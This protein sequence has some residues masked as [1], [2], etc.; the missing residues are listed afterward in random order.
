M[1]SL[2]VSKLALAN[3]GRTSS[4]FSDGRAAGHC[5]DQLWPLRQPRLRKKTSPKFRPS[6]ARIR[7]AASS[8]RQRYMSPLERRTNRLRNDITFV[9]LYV[10][11][12]TG[13]STDS[14]SRLFANSSGILSKENS[15]VS[16][17][18]SHSA[19]GRASGRS[20]VFEPA[21]RVPWPAANEDGLP[22]RHLCPTAKVTRTGS[23]LLRAS[24]SR[25][26]PGLLAIRTQRLCHLG[27][28]RR[29]CARVDQVG[30][31]RLNFKEV[32][33]PDT[34]TELH[35]ERENCKD[36]GVK[37][38][39]PRDR[40]PVGC[41]EEPPIVLVVGMPYPQETDT[42]PRWTC[43]TPDDF[44]TFDDV[45]VGRAKNGLRSNP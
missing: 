40:Q 25:L 35:P 19:R 29:I 12:R 33:D 10:L 22:L 15:T 38:L 9:K 3:Q 6:D 4:I 36:I 45:P 5:G 8:L 31:P 7:K 2:R 20:L 32:R 44:D 21:L 16:F 43:R 23:L 30:A 42:M 1:S 11:P 39:G 14:W 18:A 27:N 26:R 13:N 28:P 24:R 17:Q 41:R 37:G 34:A